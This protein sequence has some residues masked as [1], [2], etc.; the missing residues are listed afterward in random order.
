V[1]APD[2]VRLPKQ[3]LEALRKKLPDIA[4]AWPKERWYAS[5]AVEVRVVRLLGPSQAKVVVLSKSADAKGGRQ[6]DHDQVFT[7]FLDYYDGAW[8]ATRFDPSSPA[9][10]DFDSWAVRFLV[11][12]IDEAAEKP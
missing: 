11:L 1:P 12:A 4:E 5:A 2:P 10:A 6:P 3:T 7:I 9:K 8:S